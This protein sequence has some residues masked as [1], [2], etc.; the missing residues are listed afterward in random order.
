MDVLRVKLILLELQSKQ[1]IKSE[2]THTFFSKGEPVFSIGFSRPLNAFLIYHFM[3]QQ[4]K[5]YELIDEAAEAITQM[6]T[7]QTAE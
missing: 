1:Y 7:I 3:D 4:T 6:I 2:V 5:M